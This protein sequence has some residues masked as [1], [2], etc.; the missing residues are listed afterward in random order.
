MTKFVKCIDIIGEHGLL[1]VNQIYEVVRETRD[2]YYL[3]EPITLSWCKSR[4]V[5]FKYELPEP[6]NDQCKRQIGRMMAQC[7]KHSQTAMD[8]MTR[9]NHNDATRFQDIAADY[10]AI[11]VA[12]RFED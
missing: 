2:Y 1:E 11:I 10:Y 3:K 9:G 8:C 7:R 5:D 12:L 4:F 6:M